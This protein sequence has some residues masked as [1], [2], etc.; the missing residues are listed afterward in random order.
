MAGKIDITSIPVNMRMGFNDARLQPKGPGFKFVKGI[1]IERPTNAPSITRGEQEFKEM[2]MSRKLGETMGRT[3]SGAGAGR[4][5]A[6]TEA[7]AYVRDSRKVLR[8]ETFFMEAVHESPTESYRVRKI[9]LLYYLEDHT[10]QLNEHK[11]ENSGIPQGTF[12]KRHICPKGDGSN[13]TYNDLVV[14]GNVHIYGRTFRIVACDAATRAW[15]EE[16]GIPQPED[17]GFPDDSYTTLRETLKVRDTGADS[18]TFRG[19]KSNPLKR[20]MEASLGNASN[21]QR[22]GIP[23]SLKRFLENDRKVLRFYGVWDNRDAVYGERIFFRIHYFL[24]DDTMEVLEQHQ[25]NSGRDRFPALLKRQ[26]I[27]IDLAYND[28]RARGVEDDNGFNE[29]YTHDDLC[30]GTNINILGR[31]IQLYDADEF[32]KQWYAAVRGVDMRDAVVD[33]EEKKPDPPVIEAPPHTGFGSEEDSLSS[34]MF[35]TPKVPRKDFVKLTE[36]DKKM[37]RFTARLHNPS[38]IDESRQFIVTYYLAD[39]TVAVFERAMRNSGIIGGKWLARTRVK[40]I[41]TGRY[42]DK[43]DFYVGSVITLKGHRFDLDSADEYTMRVMEGAAKVWPMSQLDFVLNTVKRKLQDSS[44]TAQQMFRKVDTDHSGVISAEEFNKVLLGYGLEVPKAAML[45]LMRHYD[46][47]G[48]GT[49]S[50]GEF[51]DAF[52]DREEDGGANAGA[53]RFS[54]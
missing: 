21:V 10:L 25:P 32:T 48:D 49:I 23:D 42:F 50:Y 39:D 46:K 54:T 26:R 2:M 36:F 30:V 24:S 6:R 43:G 40:N 5:T 31:D 29:Y 20:F 8:F 33:V 3:G 45:T 51:C 11:V 16:S 27:P 53:V 44:T 18:S 28:D 37:L 7:P 17:I 13:V 52:I 35:L 38:P 19:K 47:S 4:A 1:A 41:D 15:F 12:V 9:T 34:F 22:C 14:G